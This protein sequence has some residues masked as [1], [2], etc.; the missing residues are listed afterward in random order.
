MAFRYS[1]KIVTDGLVLC[2]DAANTKSYPLSGI[3]W[4]DLS[5]SNND[6]EL[7]NSPS[8]SSSNNGFFSFDGVGDYVDFGN[9]LKINGSSAVSFSTWLYVSTNSLKLIFTRYNTS[10]NTR[11]ADYIGVFPGSSNMIPGIYIG[12][13]SDYIYWSSTTESFI[14]NKW[15]HLVFTIDNPSTNVKCYVNGVEVS[16][17]SIQSGTPPTSFNSTISNR[18]WKIGSSIPLSGIASY[19]DFNISNLL[20]YNKKLTSTE[21]LQI[22]NS[23]K[24]RFGFYD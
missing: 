4:N 2:V 10:S 23:T 12:T 9:Y 6:G 1:P 18:Y 15:N 5:L 20:I 13:T 22:F 11:I 7:K 8:F 14:L 19:Y 17:T 21:V 16:L 3:Y 24:S